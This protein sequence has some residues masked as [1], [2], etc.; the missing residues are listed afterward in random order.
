MESIDLC[1]DG[2]DHIKKLI[3]DQKLAE[4]WDFMGFSYLDWA[5]TEASDNAP[6]EEALDYFNTAIN[7]SSEDSNRRWWSAA[8]WGIGCARE[9]LG[10][11]DKSLNALH[12]ATL[13][14]PPRSAAPAWN[15]KG[16][17]L[18]DQGFHA[19][20]LEAYEKAVELYPE[21]AEEAKSSQ[22]WRVKEDACYKIAAQAHK[23]KGDAHYKVGL[24]AHKRKGGDHDTMCNQSPKTNEDDDLESREFNYAF[25]AYSRAIQF[26]DK[27]IEDSDAKSGKGNILSMMGRYKEAIKAYSDAIGI[28]SKK[29]EKEACD[30]PPMFPGNKSLL[31]KAYIG[32][33]N[34]HAKMGEFEESLIEYDR[35]LEINKRNVFA[36]NSK[37][38]AYARLGKLDTV[39]YAK[40]IEAYKK[41]IN[42]NGQYADA[43]F[44]SG[45]A[46]TSQRDYDAAIECYKMIIDLN[47][48][49]LDAMNNKGIVLSKQEKYDEAIKIFEQAI[50]VNRRYVNAFYNE[51][52][53]QHKILKYLNAINCYDKAIDLDSMDSDAP[54]NK[55]VVLYEQGKYDEAVECYDIAI[56]AN[57][58]FADAWYNKGLAFYAQHKYSEALHCFEIAIEL[59]PHLL[60]AWHMKGM[61]LK[62][63]NMESEAE[64]SFKK[65]IDMAPDYWKT[66]KDKSQI[67]NPEISEAHQEGEKLNSRY[68]EVR[69]QRAAYFAIM[70]HIAR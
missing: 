39:W 52:L 2:L 14:L 23:G 7:L 57:P 17:V 67:P 12:N 19:D 24:L 66:E 54:N 46:L 15:D 50:N 59:N 68:D 38:I 3:P 27:Y 58:R 32:K 8:Q 6:Y 10:D 69:Q 65:I 64:S 18:W 22:G 20:A 40:A 49:D 4:L 56:K 34:V 70:R 28:A 60:R 61:T 62:A 44:N 29:E 16:D 55:G 33:G 48:K 25:K 26:L 11:H 35:S 13:Y 53:A 63:Q 9:K 47:P 1:K 31:V 36:W 30:E 37:G 45:L 43:L 5:V 51:G 41:A 42:I 21:F